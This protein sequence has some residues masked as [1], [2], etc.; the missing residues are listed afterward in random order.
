[1]ICLIDGDAIICAEE[2]RFSTN[3]EDRTN[4]FEENKSNE[5]IR[6]RHLVFINKIL[7]Q[8]KSSGMRRKDV[9]LTSFEAP[10]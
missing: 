1:M 4:V 3:E 8:R 6:R 10:E 9:T 5:N 2:K 7:E